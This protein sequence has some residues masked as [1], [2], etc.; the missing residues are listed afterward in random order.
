M[1]LGDGINDAPILA[2][3]DVSLMFLDASDLARSNCDFIISA[4]NYKSLG[5]AFQLMNKTRRIIIQNLGWAVLYNF[6]AIPA[7][8]MGFITP[9]MAALGMSL[10]SLFVML[11][12]L[13][14]NDLLYKKAN[15]KSNNGVDQ[16]KQQNDKLAK[17]GGVL[18]PWFILSLPKGS[19]GLCFSSGFNALLHL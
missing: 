13:R 6:V 10:S 19:A 14:L 15:D 2:A 11:N 16:F 5:A 7:A 1:M 12:S 3:A 18:R 4:N 17:K 9:W 8:V